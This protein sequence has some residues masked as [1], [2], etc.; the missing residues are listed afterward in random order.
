[1]APV[2]GR[3]SEVA[4]IEAFLAEADRGA[5]TLAIVGEPGIGKS[6][7]WDEAVRQSRERDAVVLLARPAESESKL[8]FAG[9]ADLLSAVAPARA[10]ALPEPQ[11]H[12]LDVA[13]LRVAADRPSEPRLVGTAF[14]SLLRELA[15]EQEVVLAV[16]DLHWLDPASL[17]AFAFANRRLAA[18]PVRAIVSI[19][20]EHAELLE[21]IAPKERLRLVDLGPLSVAA[22]HRIIA[23]NLGRTFPRPTLVRVAQTSGGNPLYT[24]EIARLLD[25]DRD[26]AASLPVPESLQTLVVDRIRSLPDATRAALLT[27]ATAAR[28][29]PRLIDADALVPAEE[30]G[31]IRV[32][33]GPRIEFAHPLFAS[34]VYSS[35]P[36]SRRR[37]THLALAELVTDPEEIARHLA[38]ACEGRDGAIARKVADAARGARG[39][40]A[41]GTASELT[42][43]ALGLVEEG[44]PAAD[45][46]RLVLAED[47]QHAGDFQ[48]ASGVLAELRRDLPPGDLRARALLALAEI[49]YW[50][51]GESAAVALAEEALATA[52]DPLVRGRCQTAI[53][54]NAGTVDLSK[55]ASAARAA[56]ELLDGVAETEP[57]LVSQAL[58]ARIRAD[59][60]LGEGFDAEAADRARRLDEIAPA[61]SVDSRVVF[62]L[63]QWRRYVD[64]L[65]GASA[66]LAEAE[67]QATAEG[68]EASLANILLNRVVVETWAGRW[69]EAEELTPQMNE[70]FEQL[71]LE[72]GGINPWRAYVDAH[73]GRLDGARA[74]AGERPREPIVAM[75]WSRCLGLAELAAGEPEA[76][77]R[78]LAEAM[79]EL[80]RV[81]FR[82]PAIWRVDGDAIEAAVAVGDLSRARGLVERFEERADRSRIPWSLAVSARCRGLLLA[83]E[84][85]PAGA[86]QALARAMGAHDDCPVP[87]ERARTLLLRGQVLRRLKQK[88]PARAALEEA[89][90]VFRQLGAE[91]WAER[92]EAELRRVA[93]RR[94]PLDLSATE[95]RIA[96]LAASG[97]TNKAIAAEV[98]VTQKAV[99]ANLARA[100]RKLGIRSRAQLSR[101]LDARDVPSG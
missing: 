60:F 69:R 84:G 93:V 77:D 24:L 73:A 29:E 23:L 2:V 13:L 12:A 92:A 6:T 30:S 95:L 20:S 45:E 1:M 81:D 65:D 63:G 98:F 79:L 68:D 8:S 58:G 38:L 101:A 72:H 34:A 5:G 96:E 11:R 97:L 87:F 4:G 25:P 47:L 46:L 18:E 66:C 32:G 100:Y 37:E 88:R 85:D 9:L 49:D 76:A 35:A 67:R 90:A 57:A 64:D 39:R 50:R 80:D 14:L 55:A 10:V 7:V 44:S 16:D 70:A 33:P 83:A 61:A 31:L 74:A 41:P 17:A 99:E 75:I 22:L 28:P 71:G 82:E 43:L 19:R 91:P 51:V 42:E 15:R 78:H 36:L 54:M 26:R 21:R 3:E 94:A 40:G 53:A 62:K 86:E 89:L 48:R 52:A 59:L 27:V 56:L